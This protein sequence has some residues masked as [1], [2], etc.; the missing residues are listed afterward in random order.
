MCTEFGV[1]HGY[2]D[3]RDLLA[4]D[5]IDAVSIAVPNFLHR[6]IAIDALRAGKHV[7]CEKPMALNAAEAEEMHT[8]GHRVQAEIHDH[9]NFR[10]H[11][12]PNG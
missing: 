5:D 10:F 4:R 12:D 2:R 7:L 8:Q 3:I 6:P 11:H 9:F 1:P